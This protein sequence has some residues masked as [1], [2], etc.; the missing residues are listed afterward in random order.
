MVVLEA[1]LSIVAVSAAVAGL[2]RLSK[3]VIRGLSAYD[4]LLHS[5]R[6]E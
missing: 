4:A 5:Q 2:V 1:L 3:S 6:G